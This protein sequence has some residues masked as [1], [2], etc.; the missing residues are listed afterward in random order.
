MS[1]VHKHEQAAVSPSLIINL[2]ET[3]QELGSSCVFRL[4][5]LVC[6]L[7]FLVPE[8]VLRLER[9]GGVRRLHLGAVKHSFGFVVE[10]SLPTRLFVRVC[11]SRVV[12]RV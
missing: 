10:F 3:S 12:P 2:T 7:C 5:V 6:L 1:E 4:C 8:C 11:F 9:K